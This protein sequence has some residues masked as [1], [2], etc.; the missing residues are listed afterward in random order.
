MKKLNCFCRVYP[1]FESYLDDFIRKQPIIKAV[2]LILNLLNE[3]ISF[4][5]LKLFYEANTRTHKY[6]NI[7]PHTQL[8]IKR[9]QVL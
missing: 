8:L 3:Y 4:S 1:L 9:K 5:P 6:I 7:C 2:G